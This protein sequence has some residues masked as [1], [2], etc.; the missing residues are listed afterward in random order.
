MN[1]KNFLITGVVGGIVD[2]LLGWLFYGILFKDIYPPS[3]NQNM[4]FIFLGCMAFGFLMA[5]IFSMGESISK[6]VPGIKTGAVIGLF[7]ALYTDFFM[8][9]TNTAVNYKNMGI[10][11]GITIVMSAL[12]GSVIAVVNGKL[13]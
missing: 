10:D 12:V 3:E 8:N 6:C 5:Y 11:V 2:F 1:V 9:V 4:T 13:K 7:L